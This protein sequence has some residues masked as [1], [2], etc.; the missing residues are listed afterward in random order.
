[1][2]SVAHFAKINTNVRLFESGV[3]VF[4]YRGHL[5]FGLACAAG[6]SYLTG[7]GLELSHLAGICAG[8][9]L[10]DMDHPKSRINHRL[11][12]FRSG[13][14]KV[15]IYCTVGFLI[16]AYGLENNHVTSVL[17]LA[18]IWTGISRHR[19]FTHSLIG[20]IM[21]SVALFKLSS[22]LGDSRFFF[23]AVFGYWSHLI[24]DSATPG[25]ISWFYPIAR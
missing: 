14:W 5:L 25:G 18:L 21:F 8:V 22:V 4:N 24:S 17:G 11:L 1:M 3:S 2:K 13:F 23:A 15:A 6:V 10:P 16:L 19:T 9:M 12:K 7:I 20:G